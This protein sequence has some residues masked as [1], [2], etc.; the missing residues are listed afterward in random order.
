MIED[1]LLTLLE[2]PDYN[3]LKRVP[4]T[5]V[6]RVA[7]ESKQF[8]ATI[9][10]LETMGLN[11]M[12]HEIIELGMLSFSFTTRDGILGV[13]D[14]YNELNDPGKP[15]PAEITKV[16]HITDKD[17]QGK[18]IDWEHVKTILEKTHLIICHNSGFDRN[19]LEIQTP[20]NISSMIQSLPFAC[21][22]KDID[23]KERGIESSKLDYINWKLGYFY[24]GHRALSDCWATINPLV[25][26]PG[27]FDE[28]KA[29]VRKKETLL[30][31]VNASFDKKDLLKGRN[32]RWSDGTDRLPKSW[33]ICLSNE[34]LADEKCW[35]DETI[36]G[37]SG[38]SDS[39]P[40]CEITT[41]KRYSFRAERID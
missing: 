18:S 3:V 11:P 22:I 4:T 40:Q 41:R 8:I 14:A 37:A 2:H 35:L 39:I 1:A 9:I 30:C 31:A 28:L 27:V 19:F 25:V 32:Y 33:W 10:D 7:T 13:I 15:I 34:L 16:T 29:N 36:Y 5:L 20:K 6:S 12:N 23:W 24:D 26:V 38:A 17:V 21:T